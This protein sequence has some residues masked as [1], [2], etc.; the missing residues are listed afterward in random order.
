[1]CIEIFS[2]ESPFDKMEEEPEPEPEPE[3]PV[4]PEPATCVVQGKKRKRKV[5]SK[6]VMGDDGF[7]CKSFNLVQ[8]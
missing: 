3:Q 1:M 4:E 6:S 8:F 5:V 2:S 7:F